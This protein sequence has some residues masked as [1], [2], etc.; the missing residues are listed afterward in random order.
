EPYDVV[1]ADP[2]YALDEATLAG[3][4]SAMVSGGWLAPSALIVL[5]RP[6]T[7]PTPTWPDDVVAFT[8]RRYGDTVVY[9]G[10]AP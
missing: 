6:V 5:E 8:Y 7:A 10:C 1:L 3:V 4:L 2:P 9:Y